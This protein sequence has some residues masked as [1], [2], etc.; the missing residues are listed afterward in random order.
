MQKELIF[1]TT[2]S[3]AKNIKKHKKSNSVIVSLDNKAS[4]KLDTLGIL[5]KTI[6]DYN[7][8]IDK[9]ESISIKW[10]KKWPNSAVENNQNFK[11]IFNIEGMS[12]WWL[13]E[14]WLFYNLLFDN[15]IKEI[16]NLMQITKII[17]SNE[18]PN[19]IIVFGDDQIKL[20]II[21][22]VCKKDKLYVKSSSINIALYKIK[23]TI[24]LISMKWFLDNINTIRKLTYEMSVFR[25]QNSS[26]LNANAKKILII[27]TY[28]W[29]VQ[30]GFRHF[31]PYTDNIKNEIEKDKNYE[32][33]YVGIQ[34]GK[35]N[36]LPDMKEAL[37]NHK[38]YG[39]LENYYN[40]EVNKNTKLHLNEIINKWNNIKLKESFIKTF[41][42]NGINIW[43]LVKNQYGHYFSIRLNS[44]IRYLLL[45]KS[46]IE[47]EKP[48]ILIYPGESGDFSRCLFYMSRKYNIFSIG[49]QHGVLAQLLWFTHSKKEITCEIGPEWCPIPNITT[50]YGKYF[51]RI[52]LKHG[53]YP[54]DS[55]VVTGD[56]RINDF[57]KNAYK[58][59]KKKL[60]EKFY[61]SKENKII[62]YL[63]SPVK[64]K[65]NVYKEVLQSIKNVPK[66]TLIVKLH[67]SENP[68]F[69]KKIAREIDIK[70][71]II[72]DINTYEIITLCDIAI[73]YISTTAL[74]AMALKKPLVI[75]NLTKKLG[76]IEFKKSGVLTIYKNGQLGNTVKKL[77]E[78]KKFRINVI[79]KQNKFIYKYM[80]KI[81]GKAT[82][83]IINVIKNIK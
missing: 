34:V 33:K 78:N 45:I 43:N 28:G 6:N 29:D 69:Y 27:R 59:S 58:T 22:S 64:E 61:I 60:L 76:T 1:L 80:Y 8:D 40:D 23:T 77:L 9:I 7:I 65:Y 26:L 11:G 21:K 51:K 12:I 19:K 62:L 71:I 36:F 56:Q 57:V 39:I 17:L 70:P 15:T 18:K 10:M 54:K 82:E 67:P 83:R 74:E 53:N 25:N 42:F 4:Q 81:D 47:K 44:H 24:K 75:I 46:M 66:T 32:T 5:Y 13:M 72:R 68:D 20:D 30:K 38:E 16:L 55:V 50:V 49:M 48:S 52:L 79:K 63:T 2:E 41:D 37:K 14:N 3:N 73:T 31:N 35:Y